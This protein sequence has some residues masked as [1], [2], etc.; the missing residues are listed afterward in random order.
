MN[1]YYVD[2][3][4]DGI[5]YYKPSRQRLA[6]VNNLDSEEIESDNLQLDYDNEHLLAIL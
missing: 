3:I 1:S 6:P 4:V 2:I 5:E